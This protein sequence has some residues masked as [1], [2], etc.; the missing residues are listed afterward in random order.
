MKNLVPISN[1]EC[2]GKKVLR[3][4]QKKELVKR[5]PPDL[6]ESGGECGVVKKGC[7]NMGVWVQKKIQLKKRRVQQGDQNSNMNV[8]KWPKQRT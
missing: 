7:V 2:R 5:E 8:T 3:C 1:W 6:A 4:P